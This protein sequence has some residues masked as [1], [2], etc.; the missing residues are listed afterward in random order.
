[1][2]KDLYFLSKIAEALKQPEPKESLR[3][4]IEEIKTLGQRAEYEQGFV[5]FQRF[6]AEV[7]R[8]SEELSQMSGDI[9][10]N[11]IRFLA[12]L[13]ASDL[14]EED[15]K[16]AQAVLDLIGT[17]PGWQEEFERLRKETGKSKMTGRPPEIIIERNGEHLGSSIR[18]RP[19]ITKEIRNVK[20]GNFAVKLDT[21]RILWEEELT[22]RELI[23]AS[24]FPGQA[25]DLAADTGEENARTTRE[26]TALNGELTIRVFPGTESGRLEVKI[27]GSNLG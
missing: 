5:Q 11:E 14:L 10:S 4:A 21:G 15:P 6:M 17:H 2:T 7:K 8:N 13:A 22:E 25:L 23:W 19:P 24:A 18:E 12:L 1:M 20:P 3:A 26:I 27:R 16:E 9:V